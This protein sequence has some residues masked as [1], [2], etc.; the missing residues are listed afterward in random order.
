MISDLHVVYLTY[1]QFVS[2]KH[3]HHFPCL[4]IYGDDSVS[5]NLRYVISLEETRG[6]YYDYAFCIN[7]KADPVYS[8]QGSSISKDKFVDLV[9][10]NYPDCFDWFLWNP[11][12]L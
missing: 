1:D 8:G 9:R 10:D 3:L 12:W 2:R 11:G 7:N 6:N 5:L 4:L